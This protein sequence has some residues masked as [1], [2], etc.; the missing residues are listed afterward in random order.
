MTEFRKTSLNYGVFWSW[1]AYVQIWWRGS[2]SQQ[3]IFAA[4]AQE[5]S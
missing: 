2:I 5:A 1:Y 3:N 4:G